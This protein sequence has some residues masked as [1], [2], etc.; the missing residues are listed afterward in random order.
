MER[1]DKDGERDPVPAGVSDQVSHGDRLEEVAGADAPATTTAGTATSG[2]DPT[3]A[4][5]SKP[6]PPPRSKAAADDASVSGLSRGR[7]ATIKDYDT[8]VLTAIQ[9]REAFVTRCKDEA[10]R[11]H[12]RRL[13]DLGA[14]LLA[15]ARQGD[16]HAVRLVEVAIEARSGPS[17]TGST[18][19]GWDWRPEKS[20]AEA[21]LE[22]R[23]VK[24]RK[25]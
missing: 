9:D 23:W 2:A 16:E 8:A 21:V 7:Q 24:R 10:R 12:D 17:S 6:G 4:P 5:A 14:A 3:V 15:A 1:Q 18:L 13:R 20:E 19:R 22:F 11:T 25:R